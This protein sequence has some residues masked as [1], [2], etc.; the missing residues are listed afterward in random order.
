MKPN[1]ELIEF[2]KN[3]KSHIIVYVVS[4]GRRNSITNVLDTLGITYHIDGLITQETVKKAKP[5]PDP[6]LHALDVAG[7]KPEDVVVFEDNEIGVESAKA[8]GITDI[9]K[10]DPTKF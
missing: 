9:V 10:V 3:N 7:L 1:K 6:Y 2:I 4:N 8:A 5:N